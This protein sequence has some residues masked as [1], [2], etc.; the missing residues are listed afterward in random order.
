MRTT[1]PF[2][3]WNVPRSAFLLLLSIVVGT[4]LAAASVGWGNVGPK[5]PDRHFHAIAYDSARGRVV[6]FGGVGDSGLLSDT[7]EWDGTAWVNVTPAVSPPARYGHALAYDSS[8]GRVVLFGGNGLNGFL[9][10]TWEWDGTAWVNV[11]PAVSPPARFVHALTYDSARARI[12]LFG[13]RSAAAPYY[14]ADTWEWDGTT[15]VN[16]TPAVSPPARSNHAMAYDSARGRVVLFGGSNGS[17]LDD[18]WERVGTVWVRV[19]PAAS[20]PARMTYAMAYESAR[21]RVVLFGGYGNGFLADTWEWDGAAWV[22]VTPA[23]SP[24]AR[25]GH[26]MA[27]DSARGRV[28]LFGGLREV[29]PY[30]LADTWEWDGSAWVG[31]ALAVSPPA[32]SDHALAYDSARGRVVLFGG[33]Q[34]YF[35]G[36]FLA[37]TWEWD[38]TTWSDVTPA[39]SPPARSRHAMVYDS[40]RGRVVLFG[41]WTGYSQFFAD[42]WE[43]DGSSWVKVTPSVSPPPR[44]GH[45][46][47]YDSVRGRVVLFGGY[48]GNQYLGDT[49]EWDG[50]TWSNVSPAVS[51]PPRDS[52]AVAYDSARGR[53]VLFGGYPSGVDTWE[54]DGASWVNATPAVSPLRRYAHAMAYDSARGRVVLFGGWTGSN[55]FFADTWEWD[56]TAWVNVTPALSP[57]AR[58]DH[59]LTY[60]VARSRVV[61]FGGWNGDPVADTW[62]YPGTEFLCDGLDDNYNGSI[63][64]GCDDDLDGYC[65]AAMTVVGSPAVCSLGA[66]DCDDTNP[67]I[68]PSATETCDGKDNDCDLVVD[69]G[70]P[71]GGLSC[72]TGLQGICSIGT[73]NCVAGSI[74]CTQN[75]QPAA[76][77]CDNL[78]NNCNGLI[79][80]DAA[81]LDSDSDGVHNACDNCRFAFNPSQSD[82]DHDRVGNACDNCLTT[83]NPSQTDT[84]SDQ[85]GDVC[86]NCPADYNPSQ[87]NADGDRA[88]DVCDNCAFTP[89]DDQA[90]FDHDFEGDVCDLNDGLIMVNSPA[91]T[92]VLYQR[93]QGFSSYNVYRGDMK[94][95]RTTGIFTQDPSLVP[96]ADQ[97]C[98]MTT[99]SLFDPFVPGLGRVV[100]YLVTGVSAGSEGSLGNRSNGTPRP[101]DNPC[102]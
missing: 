82:T 68:H 11:T 86:D 49:W 15:W 98:G 2:C 47:A 88:G 50:T 69:D 64:E 54:W 72:N 73:T 39:V 57:P 95:L 78:D 38:G 37:D 3:R 55:D 51:P 62:D 74:A 70:N 76:E 63:D 1:T 92:S 93:E 14:L 71:G 29:S 85:R 19:M 12:V 90:D 91:S 97:F 81:G 75:L 43:W 42:T 94:T 60:D 16:V 65:D 7:L 5:P 67:S 59:A 41:G 21:G 28:I 79:D 24:P 84:D 35:S 99:G 26:A 87:D 9:A 8:R 96:A 102:Q 46:L 30:Y 13:G 66:G 23:V 101:N 32:R 52:H 100:Y 83:Y 25:Y 44:E 27:Y 34:N 58:S 6:L 22:D 4:T 10:D 18:T 61:L 36:P 40:A 20:P 31:V 77:V 53:V 56:G 89:N 33:S 80:E 45:A 17:H 48:N